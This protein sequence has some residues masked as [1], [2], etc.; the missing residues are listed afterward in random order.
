MQ[1]IQFDRSEGEA[2]EDFGSRA[3]RASALGHGSGEAHAH[4][5]FLGPGGIIGP[6]PAGF[7]QLFVVL[8]GNAWVS[9]A[10]GRR[11][12]VGPGQAAYIRRGETPAK[13]SDGG[14]TALMVQVRDFELAPGT[15]AAPA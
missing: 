13:G 15:Q 9:D 8:R 6:H 4:I 3:A 11:V 5:V 10:D 2:V 12:P 7:A 1:V 14:S